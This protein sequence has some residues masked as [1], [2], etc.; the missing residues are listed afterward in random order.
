MSDAH[1]SMLQGLQEVLAANLKRAIRDNDIIYVTPVPSSGQL[2]MIVPAGMV[3]TALPAPVEQSLDWISAEPGYPLF[4][5]LVPYGVHLA[6][7][8]VAWMPERCGALLIYLPSKPEIYEDRK[9]TFVH[10][11]LEKQQDK[12]DGLTATYVKHLPNIATRKPKPNERVPPQ[13]ITI[14][15]LTWVHYCSRA[16]RGSTSFPL[17]EG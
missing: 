6:L 10:D 8:E 3:K 11:E 5:G 15:R 1:P 9:T 7:G 17:E 2:S 4:V 12:I 14:V 13:T 16:T